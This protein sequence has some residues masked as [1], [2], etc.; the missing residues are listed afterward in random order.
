MTKQRDEIS[1][2]ATTMREESK[3]RAQQLDLL[4]QQIKRKAEERERLEEEEREKRE[5][6]NEKDRVRVVLSLS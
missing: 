6:I 2:E 5:E 4:N 3:S 1:L